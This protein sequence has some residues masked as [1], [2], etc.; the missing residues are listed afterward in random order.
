MR[1]MSLYRLQELLAPH[2]PPCISLYQ[3]TH[4]HHPSNQ[5]DPIRYKNLVTEVETSLREKYRNREIR[6]LIETFRAVEDDH[7]FWNYTL[8]GL[9][10]FATADWF[11]A[12]KFQRPVPELAIVAD[13]LHVKP[14]VRIVQSADRYQVLCLSRQEAKLYEGNRDVLDPVDLA[15]GIPRTNAETLSH[16]QDSNDPRFFRAVDQGVLDH[17]SRPSG[18]PLIVVAT[19]DN[20]EFF[21]RVTKNPSLVGDGVRFD[22]GSL[23]P[24]RLREEVWRVVQPHYLQRLAGL[25]ENFNEARA[26]R[27]ASGDLSDIAQAA[28]ANQVATLLVDADR[29]EPGTLDRATGRINFSDLSQPRVDDLLDDLAELV[30]AKGGEVVVVPADRMPT[31]SGA[32]AIFRF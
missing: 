18:L 23:V 6:P 10:V 20:L 19:T 24:D 22:P 4:R 31:Q 30:L 16:D 8:D 13:S 15:D 25:V 28:V 26:K 27:Q 9:A 2:S 11:R 1:S 32:A 14:L 17:H 7:E 29:Q 12:Y 5:Q 3:P 21:R